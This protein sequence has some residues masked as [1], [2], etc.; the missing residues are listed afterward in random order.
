M[1]RQDVLK[2][3][4]E[5]IGT[6]EPIEFFAKMV[7][8]FTLLFDELDATRHELH[9]VKKQSALAIQ[10]EPKIAS[11]MISDQVHK[12]RSDLETKD[13]YDA[14]ISA[15]KRAFAEDIVTQNYNDFCNFW[16]DTLGWHPFLDGR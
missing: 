9:N 11:Q 8:V 15:L 13:V 14:E 16:Q 2:E 6:K 10:W 4:K 1:N 12:L 3:M 5:S 7:D